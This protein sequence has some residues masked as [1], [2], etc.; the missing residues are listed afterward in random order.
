M[1]ASLRTRRPSEAPRKAQRTPSKLSKVR[2]A[3]KSRVDD[4]IKKRMSMRYADISSPTELIP[5]PAVPS[6][7]ITTSPQRL[8]EPLRE[9]EDLRDR[10]SRPQDTTDDKKLLSSEDFDAD[11]FIKRK[12]A[13]STEA[14][15]KSL[16]SAL[17]DAKNDTAS[18]LQRSVFKNYAEF[19]LI[20]KEISVL[21]N[22]MLELK[23]QLSE[24][25]SMPS[26]LHVP[27]PTSSSTGTLSTYKRS[28][29]ADLRVLYFNQMQALHA[30]IEGAAKFVPTTPGR[31]V[32]N[33]VEGVYSLNAATYKIIGKVKF[34]IL[35]DAVL[36]ARR[37]RRNA[38]PGG[39][40][41]TV[42]EGKLV[43]E[44]CWPLN[45]MLVLDTKDSPNMTNVFK[46]RQGKETHVYRSDT[47]AEKKSLLAQFRQV[48]DELSAK[49]RKEREGEH[50][51]RKTLWHDGDRNSVAPPMPEWMVDLA[52]RGGDFP[53]A[54]D[55]DDAKEKAEKDARWVGEW[56]DDLTVAI[57]LREWSK[58]VE[59]V[60]QGQA[61][62]ST[63]PSLQTKLPNL[64]NRLTAALLTSLSLPSNKKSTSVLVV[65]L[66]VR[67]KAAAAARKT[68]L[69][70]RTSVITG[71]MRRIRF[72]GDISSYVGDL[73]VV[74]FTGIKHTADW[75]LASFKDNESTS[76]FVVWAQDQLKVFAEMFRKQ[77][78]TKDVEPA[79]VQEAI[80]IAQLESR[81]L[82]QEHGLDFRY[83]L[84]QLVVEKPKE[85]DKGSTHFSFAAHRLS[86]Q[87]D[88]SS[89]VKQLD[90]GQSTPQPPPQPEEKEQSSVQQLPPP[91]PPPTLSA[92]PPTRRR[93]PAP[94]SAFREP[95]PKSMTPPTD[96]IPTPSKT[97]QP[98][99]PSSIS[100]YPPSPSYPTRS[101]TPVAAPA[102]A[103]INPLPA[104]MPLSPSTMIPPMSAPVTG[105]GTPS[106][107][108][109][110]TPPPNSA[111]LP[112]ALT[113][114][115]GRPGGSQF[116]SIRDRY[117][118]K[119][120]DWET[121]STGSA[122]G[123][124]RVRSVRGNPLLPPRSANRP[125]S[126]HGNNGPSGQSTPRG[127]VPQREGMI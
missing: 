106:A 47:A 101:R 24:Y 122:G 2:D 113:P 61:R 62:S 56:S 50:E 41:S 16:Q 19:V 59:L 115:S 88:L 66:L 27:D 17:H 90:I 32:I 84:D 1:D 78:Y 70:M 98:P 23:E 51:R 54:D 107:R 72:G 10:S 58:A 74:W 14:E 5:V 28:S 42:N 43:A 94:P 8:R 53:G 4:K 3:R 119:D 114:G 79:V 21:E 76:A 45:D 123:S 44:K 125:G 120:R 127:V 9:D 112:A 69:E 86:K 111:G 55:I 109:V 6:L 13:N 29:V 52:R 46:I 26:M 126:Q 99:P 36:V 93:T 30:S 57:A 75:Y 96:A 116:G 82:L 48:S 18:D 92:P 31:H 118:D 91:P 105:F 11:A 89:L 104:S 124:I 67:L 49:K 103:N 25:K 68:F 37:R 108:K 110:R 33:E 39:D 34:V 83:L 65:S 85:T 117:V 38:G 73:S 64:T 71:L 97:P 63:I 121:G 15:L 100:V 77:V 102:S 22:D 7:P 60:E 20:S 87:G 81:K 40:G 95:S 35:D 12:L 80:A